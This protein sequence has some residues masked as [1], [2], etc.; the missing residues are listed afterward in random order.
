MASRPDGGPVSAV[1]P[2]L[3]AATSAHAH[4]GLAAHGVRVLA[5]PRREVAHAGER[6]QRG[7]VPVALGALDQER[8]RM[9]VHHQLGADDRADAEP[10]GLADEAH[11]AA[12]VGGVGDADRGVAE[13]GGAL[14]E[15][16]GGDGAVAEGEGGSGRGVRCTRLA[17]ISHQLS[18]IRH[19][20]SSSAAG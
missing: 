7:E 4:A 12:E 9:A 18:V 5:I 15:R 8:G 1:S 10:A 2:A 11:H 13:L 3:R 14:D 16:F 17:A 20:S 6:D 19:R